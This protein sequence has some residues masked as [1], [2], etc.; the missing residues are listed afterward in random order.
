VLR[1]A[2][3]SLL[4][5]QKSKQVHA[6]LLLSLFHQVPSKSSHDCDDGELSL[7][8]LLDVRRENIDGMKNNWRVRA[9]GLNILAY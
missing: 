1:A 6:S 3:P 2:F 7:S 5:G 8:V 9:G 4:A